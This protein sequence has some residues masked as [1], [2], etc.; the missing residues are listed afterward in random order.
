MNIFPFLFP[1]LY[2]Q[3]AYNLGQNTSKLIHAFKKE[4]KIRNSSPKF[5]VHSSINQL[6]KPTPRSIQALKFKQAI[7]NNPEDLAQVSPR[8]IQINALTI[9]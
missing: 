2:I 3:L 4:N 9:R 7:A 5:Q 8:S 1:N 6:L